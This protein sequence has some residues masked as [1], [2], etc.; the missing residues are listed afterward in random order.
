MYSFEF[1]ETIYEEG[2]SQQCSNG[3]KGGSKGSGWESQQQGFKSGG[4]DVFPTHAITAYT[5]VLIS[6]PCMNCVHVRI[7]IVAAQVQK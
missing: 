6:Q 5:R 2:C 4:F 1:N 3:G 7:L